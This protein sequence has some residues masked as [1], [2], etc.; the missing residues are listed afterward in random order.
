V[1]LNRTKRYPPK[2]LLFLLFF[3]E[4][5]EDLDKIDEMEEIRVNIILIFIGL[6]EL[7]LFNMNAE[8]QALVKRHLSSFNNK[9]LVV[10][11]KILHNKLQ[12]SKPQKLKNFIKV[13]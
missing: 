4:E 13:S 5:G 3:S 1:G 10:Q 11:L 12:L 6:V 7:V 8:E 2:K 9:V